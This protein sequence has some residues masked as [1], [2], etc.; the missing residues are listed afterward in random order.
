MSEGLSPI[1]LAVLAVYV[2][3]VVG[4]GTYF[5][6]S[7][8]TTEA[9]T[10]ANRSLSGWALGLSLLGTNL[11]SITFL[12][13]PA[14]AY[15]YDWNAA[16]P[17]IVF[18]P[19][20][21]VVARWIVPF[22]RLSLQISAYEH[23]ERRFGP[24]ARNYCTVCFVLY[25]IGRTGTVLFLVSVAMNTLLGWDVVAIIV[26]TGVLVTL[27]TL[28]G[29]IEAVIW[30]DVL[31]SIVLTAGAVLCMAVLVVSMPGGVVQVFEL[32][33]WQGKFSV[34][35][36]DSTLSESTFWVMLVFAIFRDLASA[37]TDQTRVQRY[38]AAR[39]TRE[40][41]RSVW[42]LGL[43]YVPLSV[44]F[45][46]IGTALFGYY[47]AQPELLPVELRAPEMAERIF[48]Y[49]IVSALPEGVTGLLIAA[50]FAAA[51]STVDS[52]MNSSATLIL[53]DFYKR[54]INPEVGERES[55]QLLY[56]STL[57]LGVLGTATALGLIY[58]QG[59]VLETWWGFESA[60]TGGMF[61]MFL[62]A[63]L[64]KKATSSSAVT[65][66]TIGTLVV[67][68]IAFSP[69]IPEDWPVLRSGFHKFM[70]VILGT[71][72]VF[73]VGVALSGVRRRRERFR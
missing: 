1:D 18:L 38:K 55:M 61:G 4:L 2:V 5:V 48:P 50:M 65:G 58:S 6:R 44:M 69:Y 45:F 24:W 33:H 36:F 7:G 25:Q 27:Y 14:T 9:F 28:L 54:Y 47:Q 31:Q 23:F 20:M 59:G 22:F 68:W 41:Q 51:M 15:R 43:T 53:T 64:S 49:F 17:V 19:A 52:G 32:A 11:S 3:A 34:G 73:L 16:V 37:S 8:R 63:A 57:V 70:A 30:T 62:L 42:L 67:L 40:A 39:S 71:L 29:G 56:G 66:V 60:L 13:Y 10:A 35:S 21:W 12:S 26:V 46:F 72:T